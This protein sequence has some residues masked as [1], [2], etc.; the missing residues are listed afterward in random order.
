MRNLVICCDGTW[1]TNDQENDDGV[2]IPTNVVRFRNAIADKDDLN[3]EQ[4]TYYHPG[5]GTEGHWWDR[6]I[7]GGLGIGL[8]KNILSAYRWL[9]I[10]YR[11]GDR[12]FLI[13]FS[14]G[15]FTVRSLGGMIAA[16]GLV[17]LCSVAT[18][19]EQWKLV[20]D[21]Y[22]DGYRRKVP[23]WIQ[24][25]PVHR[26][27]N[28]DPVSIHFLGVWD[29]VGALGIPNDMAILNLL[30]D[31]RRY[32]FHNTRLSAKVR[33]ARHA[34]ALDEQR[35]SFAPALWTEDDGRTPKADIPLADFESGAASQSVLQVWFPGVHC[36]V[37][38]GYRE[39]GL[40]DG[41]LK[42]MM[43]EA[44][45]VGLAFRKDMCRQVAPDF[46]DVLHDS[47]CGGFK[48][49]RCQPRSVPPID[50][51]NVHESA[52]SRHEYPPI[53]QSPYRPTIRLQ[54]GESASVPVFA[55]QL[56]N[57]TG[58]YLDAGARYRLEASGEWLDR[59]LKCTPDG[60]KPGE[61]QIG[62]L[63]QAAG[64]LL[65]KMEKLY[66][67]FTDNE[68]A[69]FKGSR[70]EE[71]IPWFALVGTIAN[72]LN[73]DNDGTPPA[74]ETFMIGSGATIPADGNAGVR[75]PGYL[76]CFANDSWHFYGNNRGSVTLKVTR[77]V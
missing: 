34:V 41:A 5:V 31:P 36:D 38:G 1:N 10:H 52:K 47:L 6:L 63:G 22:R 77:L 7:G 8:D 49:F 75:L 74:H 73:P 23:G 65:G 9:A 56:W 15:A 69:D 2:P 66:K 24:T 71:D 61:F 28:G 58:I 18:E 13:G 29:T 12:I 67:R 45:S 14:R 11:T 37:G 55:R 42:W 39:K 50:A 35:A 33:H 44:R 27:E 40:S 70:R 43:D 25:W 30:D 26:D 62:E 21:L 3:Q 46:Q 54:P 51:G 17:D 4:L 16:C 76:F 48:L 20:N 72:A 19:E 68:Q 64:T 32:H 60:V 53:A 59:D 57:D